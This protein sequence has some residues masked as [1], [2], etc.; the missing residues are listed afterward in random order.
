MIRFQV[1]E[2]QSI[3]VSLDKKIREA[4][5]RC[6]EKDTP[7]FSQS[8]GWN[9]SFPAWTV[10]GLTEDGYPAVH[11]GIIEREILVNQIPVSALGIQNVYVLPE[12]RGLGMT[13]QLMDAV[14]R[15]GRLRKIDTG[16][17]FCRPHI[18]KVYVRLGWRRAAVEK[19][20]VRTEE[21][22]AMER[23]LLHD[24][25]FWYPISSDREPSGIIDLCGKDW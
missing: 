8:R 2:E 10:V 1:I 3:S 9:G 22:A 17:L 13:G 14:I 24:N 20:V 21:G 18:E 23:K 7:Y 12:Y 16:L 19:I 6:F 11:A 15:E 5:C 25:L 4:L